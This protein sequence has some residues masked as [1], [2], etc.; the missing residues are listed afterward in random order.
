MSTIQTTCSYCSVGCNF[1]VTTEEGLIQKF[2]PSDH[3]VN[4]KKSCPKGFNLPKA[5]LNDSRLLQPLL[6]EGSGEKK[7]VSWDRALRFFADKMKAVQEKY[8]KESAAFISTGQ[9]PTNEMALLG[10]VGRVG[11]GIHGDGNT[12][13]CMATAAVG[14]KQAFGF[15]APPFT[16]EDLELTD[17]AVFIGANPVI[18]HPII[19]DRLK[20]NKNNPEVIVIDPRRTKTADAATVHV[21]VRPKTDL[22]F[23]YGV[24]HLLIRDGRLDRSF[25]EAHT[26]GF[27]DFRTHVRDFTPEKVSSLTGIPAETLE[28]VARLIGEKKRV[29]LWW[30]M[31]VNQSHQGVRT[32]QAIINIALMTG[33]IGRPGTGANSI[34]G[35]ANAMGSRLFSNT[36]CLFGGRDFAREEDRKFIADL[37]DISADRIPVKPTLP[38]DKIIEGVHE[39]TIK[40]LWVIATNPVHSWIDLNRLEAGLEKL[41]LL[42]VQDLWGD[43]VTTDRADL[44]LPAAGSLE[45]EGFFINS[46][47]RIGIV[48][49]VLE[50]LGES[51]TDFEIFKRMAHYYGC[52]DVI[53]NFDTTEKVVRVLVDSTK[54]MPCD[55]SLV[56]DW[57]DLKSKNGIQ[58]PCAEPAQTEDRARRLF[59]SGAF[60]TPDEK[61][62]FLFEDYVPVD[63][64]A[65]PDESYPFQLLTGRGTVIQFHTQTRTQRAPLLRKKAI[66]DPYFEMNPADAEE[67]GIEEGETVLLI[68]RRGECRLK[69]VRNDSLRRKDIFVPMHY[70][71]CNYLTYPAFDPYSR[72]P[73]YKSGAVKIKKLKPGT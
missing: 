21:P 27:E 63:A 50:P 62:K 64:E 42:V 18:A 49:K 17:C 37:L 33:N 51:L 43:T 46:E 39:G 72:E 30:T 65:A 38:Y 9:M 2:M 45:K 28:K 16:Y 26:K 59:E 71:E 61:A 34:T 44:V 7:P 69:A 14:Y 32:V 12:R 22:P 60:Y 6:R 4:R 67:L 55:I 53:R 41:D 10:L 1:D 48:N 11:M 47:R 73:S 58:W 24:A 35:Q 36:T 70:K 31:G 40:A 13:Q 23:L 29:S 15:D 3:V 5:M 8:G 52:E 20:K 57:E 56:K 19:W 25:I 66:E 54:G 68:S